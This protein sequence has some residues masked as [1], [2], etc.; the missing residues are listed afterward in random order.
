MI[1]TLKPDGS[2]HVEDN[3]AST[4]T[5]D[6]A[7]RMLISTPIQL[8]ANQNYTI[9][10]RGMKGTHEMVV[11]GTSL[12]TELPSPSLHADLTFPEDNWG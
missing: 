8:L 7:R 3:T 1:T 5:G 6:N 2:W 9:S 10:V 11:Y 4:N 12:G